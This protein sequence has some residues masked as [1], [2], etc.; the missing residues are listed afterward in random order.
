[1]HP[2]A[3]DDRQK[4]DRQKTNEMPNIRGG[5]IRQEYKLWEKTLQTQIINSCSKET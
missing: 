3:S 5:N 4:T 1:M 2:V